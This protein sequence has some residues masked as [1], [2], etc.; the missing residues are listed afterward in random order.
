MSLEQFS[1]N[2]NEFYFITYQG[3]LILITDQ[4]EI[5]QILKKMVNKARENYSENFISVHGFDKEKGWESFETKNQKIYKLGNI[6]SKIGLKSI[7]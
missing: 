5:E 7:H 6:V 2:L 4:K 1:E 3:E